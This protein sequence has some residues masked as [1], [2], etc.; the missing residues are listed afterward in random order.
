MGKR[1][2]SPPTKRTFR[3]ERSTVLLSHKKEFFSSVTQKFFRKSFRF[4]KIAHQRA[5]RFIPVRVFMGFS[6]YT[7]YA[8]VLLL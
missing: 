7:F 3:R 4:R 5:L 6:D 2:K 8:T 1:P